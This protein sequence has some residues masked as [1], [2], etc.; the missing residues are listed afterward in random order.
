MVQNV[1]STRLIARFEDIP[2]N[3]NYTVQVKAETRTQHGTPA[4]A[5]CQMPSTIPDRESFNSLSVSRYHNENVWGLHLNLPKISQRKGPICCYSVVVVKMLKGLS[6]SSLPEPQNLPVLTYDE[7]HRQGA[8]AY[9]AELLEPN[10][11]PDGVFLGDNSRI[12][13]SSLPCKSCQGIFWK[14][15]DQVARRSSIEPLSEMINVQNL[16]EDGTLLP[17]SNYTTFIRVFFRKYR[18]CTTQNNL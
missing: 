5:S 14:P 18:I 3:T 4:F 7:A 15:D 9:I 1:D 10:R 6:I 2:A 12:D 17:E 8:G 13:A 11:L 16:S